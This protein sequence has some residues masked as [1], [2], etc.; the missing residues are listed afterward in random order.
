MVEEGA[1]CLVGVDGARQSQGWGRRKASLATMETSSRAACVRP[2]RRCCAKR[3]C[4]MGMSRR[5][6]TEGKAASDVRGPRMPCARRAAQV[7][8]Q[9]LRWAWSVWAHSGPR[10][11]RVRRVEG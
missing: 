3:R 5:V 1:E 10:G 9:W 2:Q 11:S 7:R 8:G 4:A 6:S